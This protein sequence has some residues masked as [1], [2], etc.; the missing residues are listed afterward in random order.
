MNEKVKHRLEQLD[1]FEEGSV[2]KTM[3]LSQHEFVTK[4][5]MLNEE[6]KKVRFII[7]NIIENV[8]STC[9]IYI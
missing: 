1:D 4:I 5:N 7:V 3:G 2:R 8:L 6:I 9:T